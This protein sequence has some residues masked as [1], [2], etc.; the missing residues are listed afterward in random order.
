MPEIQDAPP[1]AKP[2]KGGARDS[3]APHSMGNSNSPTDSAAGASRQDG[4]LEPAAIE[5]IFGSSWG[6]RLLSPSLDRSSH[7]RQPAY[8]LPE[9]RHIR[10][11]RRADDVRPDPICWIDAR[12]GAYGRGAIT[13]VAHVRKISLEEAAARLARFAMCALPGAADELER[14]F[15]S[16]S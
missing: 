4:L 14:M 9:L 15:R 8:V 5:R 7:A 12:T 6:L 16:A 10:L 11:S 13:L 1:G 3:A 2:E